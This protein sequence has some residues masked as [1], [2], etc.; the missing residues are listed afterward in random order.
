MASSAYI[1]ALVIHFLSQTATLQL[2]STQHYLHFKVFSYW[3][4][5]T[6]LLSLK[7]ILLY[8]HYYVLYKYFRTRA[9]YSDIL[10]EM[11]TAAAFA[12]LFTATKER[13]PRAKR[14]PLRCAATEFC[15]S[16][17]PNE[18]AGNERTPTYQLYALPS[19]LL[20]F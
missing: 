8:A 2:Q 11:Q 13:E 14:K 17:C 12:E 16:K 5:I 15:Y 19:W 18:C 3:Q 6:I 20:R 10:P 7:I 9:A 1:F 4:K